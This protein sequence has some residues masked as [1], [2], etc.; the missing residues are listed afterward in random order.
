MVD[1]LKLKQSTIDYQTDR[2]RKQLNDPEL[3]SRMVALS[4]SK[5]GEA[6]INELVDYVTR[7][8]DH[9]GKAFVGLCHKLIKE[10]S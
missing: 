9:P 8:S 6:K 3:G 1:K 5:L 10:K 4:L 2:L 7:K